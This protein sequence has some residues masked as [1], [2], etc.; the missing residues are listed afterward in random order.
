MVDSRPE[1]RRKCTQHGGR[2]TRKHGGIRDSGK[3]AKA[4]FP[5]ILAVFF[6]IPVIID[7]VVADEMLL[8]GV[9]MRARSYHMEA[10]RKST[11][12]LNGVSPH[13]EEGTCRLDSLDVRPT[14]R[15]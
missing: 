3:A 2:S 10:Q 6:R 8:C 7:G 11:I 14:R 1:N 4:G 9:N 5:G 15:L 12:F 13:L